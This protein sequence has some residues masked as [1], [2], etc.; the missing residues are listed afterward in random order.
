MVTEENKVTKITLVP[1]PKALKVQVVGSALFLTVFFIFIVVI[2]G[3]TISGFFD[4]LSK[5]IIYL[6]IVMLYGAS[7]F[8]ALNGTKAKFKCRRYEITQDTV[9]TYDGI[10]SCKQRVNNMKGMVGMELDESTIGKMFHYGT[11]T[12]K[13]LGGAEVNIINIDN[14]EMYIPKITEIVNKGSTAL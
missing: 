1:S 12:L 6:L 8:F 9:I 5:L 4:F 11:I 10:F 13:F 7:I 14:P 3:F 2:F